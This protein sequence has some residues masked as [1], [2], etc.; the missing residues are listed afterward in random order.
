MKTDEIKGE[1][2]TDAMEMIGMTK[3]KQIIQEVSGFVPVFEAILEK[4]DDHITA[5]VFGRR[6]QYCRMED[7]VCKASLETIA[8]DL[9]LS[10]ATIMR[11][12]E[13]LVRDKYLI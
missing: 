11:H 1:Y 3:P 7:G 9:K 2:V 6:W 8:N 12:T 10:K 13:L 5:L 4:Y